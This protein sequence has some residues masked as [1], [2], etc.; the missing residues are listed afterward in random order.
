MQA[1]RILDY[2]FITL[3][4]MAMGA[5]DVVPGVSGGTIA[6]ISGIYEELITSI[7]NINLSLISIL[8]KEGI[9]AVWNKINGNF[10]LSLFLGIFIS[11]LSLAKF[12]SWLLENEPILLWSFFFGLVVASIFMVGKEI[13]RW[14]L[15]TVVVLILG[16]ALAFFITELPASDNSG[17]LPYLFL[18]GALAICAM[19]LPGISGAFILVLLGSYKTILDAVHQ[20]DIKIILTVG[21]GAIFGLLSFARLL[22]WMFNHYKNI[23]LAL[24]T[25]FILGS[26]NKIWPWK[27]VLETKTF[28]EKTIVVDDMNVLPG[29]FEGDS[30]LILAIVLA[31]LGFSLIFI[32]EKVASKK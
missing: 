3:K 15:G 29:A 10:L 11:V 20:R 17:S 6:F 14:N 9:K 19:I 21:V 18:S 16:A 24:L 5:A 30:K 8:K 22:K 26:L 2:V 28:G 25:G 12:L 1:R 31:I 4:G 7:N 13:T 23:T 27:K 32:L